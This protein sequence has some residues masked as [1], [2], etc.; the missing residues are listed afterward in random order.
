[1]DAPQKFF[2]QLQLG[3]KRLSTTRVSTAGCE[4]V[5]DFIVA[6]KS[7]KH[8]ILA[9]YQPDQLSLIDPDGRT[10]DP[11]TPI[12]DVVQKKGKTFVVKVD[13]LVYID[14]QPMR[15]SRRKTNTAT[16]EARI[17]L[18]KVAAVFQ[19]EYELDLYKNKA[20]TFDDV[21]HGL[22][23]NNR[24]PAQP[25]AG[26]TTPIRQRLTEDEWDYFEAL[27]DYTTPKAHRWPFSEVNG[28][29][30]VVLPDPSYNPELVTSA[31]LNLGVIKPD[32]RLVFRREQHDD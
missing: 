22:G 31:L 7:Q 23:Y 29:K 6:V 30:T 26:F 17:I 25:K 12:D 20:A 11:M 8:S 13:S 2:I 1:M 5:L 15:L 4:N 14:S 24:P 10:I 18:T 16:L 28:E 3:N 9:A 19:K 32:E 21:L 27:N